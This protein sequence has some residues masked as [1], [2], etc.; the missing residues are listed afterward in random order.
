MQRSLLDPADAA[1]RVH[2]AMEILGEGLELIIA[3]NGRDPEGWE[4][5]KR[6]LL[7]AASSH[8]EVVG[9]AP[10]PMLSDPA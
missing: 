4:H 8:G 3:V 6:L 5:H 7:M 9:N 1:P 10:I 2:E